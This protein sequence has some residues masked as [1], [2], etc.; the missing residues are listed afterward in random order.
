MYVNHY[1]R[2]E[3]PNKVIDFIKA[4]PFGI[5][6][7]TQRDTGLPIASHV[8]FWLKEAD[9]DYFLLFHLARA[10]ELIAA[11]RQ[12]AQVLAIF[13]GPHAYI[14]PSWYRDANV[15]T[16]NYQAVHVYG[17]PAPLSAEALEEHVAEIM[18]AYESK[19]AAGRRYGDFTADYKERA[20]RGIE[21]FSVKIENVEAAFKLSQN[22]TPED[23]QNIVEQLKN[24]P[25]SLDKE[26]AEEMEKL[27]MGQSSRSR[28]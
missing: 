1:S 25:A 9:G 6:V 14:S 26:L 12:H 4:H 22:R 24:S 19:F 10:N 11:L 2:I 3:D 27:S 20:L 16:W 8:P 15:P 23:F 5:L 18:D 13:Q 7:S 21:G 28:E 17:T